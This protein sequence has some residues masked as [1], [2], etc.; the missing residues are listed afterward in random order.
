MNDLE[1]RTCDI[2]HKEM[3]PVGDTDVYACENCD[4]IVGLVY[5]DEEE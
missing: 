4:G 2:C 1:T 3:K 5:E